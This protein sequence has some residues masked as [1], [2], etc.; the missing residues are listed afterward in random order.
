ME[1]GN[2]EHQA[3]ACQECGQGF[4][5]ASDFIL[6]LC[7]SVGSFFSIFF[8]SCLH[9]SN[10]NCNDNL[11][12]IRR[13][14]FYIPLTPQARQET[15]SLIIIGGFAGVQNT[16]QNLRNSKSHVKLFKGPHSASLQAVIILGAF[17]LSCCV[18]S[19]VSGVSFCTL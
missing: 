10:F 3:F 5:E 6:W 12:N 2:E 11:F 19:S 8:F 7:E 15:T 14:Y 1:N 9:N 16:M 4:Y 18:I 13:R 17:S